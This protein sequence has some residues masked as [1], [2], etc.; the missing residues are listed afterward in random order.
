MNLTE[1]HHLIDGAWLAGEASKDV[2]DPG[3]GSIV[4]HVSW[5]SADDAAPEADAA[6]AG[7]VC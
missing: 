5:G 2:V 4:G 6:A 3:N 7:F 1:A